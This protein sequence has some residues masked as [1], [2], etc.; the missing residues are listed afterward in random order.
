MQVV[1]LAALGGR[2]AGGPPRTLSAL[3]S[4]RAWE[5]SIGL[6]DNRLK[7]ATDEQSQGS[8]K[9]SRRKKPPPRE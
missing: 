2:S 7:E 3:D 1:M 6:E 4:Y 8:S 9:K 5:R